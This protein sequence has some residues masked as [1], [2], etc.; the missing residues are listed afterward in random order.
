[1]TLE[2]IRRVK[3]EQRVKRR[4]AVEVVDGCVDAG[5]MERREGGSLS[6]KKGATKG[7]PEPE[8]VSGCL[9]RSP[10][11]R[12]RTSLHITNSNPDW[13]LFQNAAYNIGAVKAA[14][15]CMVG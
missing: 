7:D 5:R 3:V 1:M 2:I 13:N 10:M 11:V 4:C 9:W 15:S 12:W 8:H 6:V 14:I